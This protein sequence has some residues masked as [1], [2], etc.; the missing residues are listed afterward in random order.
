[1]DAE[2]LQQ[3]CAAGKDDVHLSGNSPL[4]IPYWSL[5]GSASENARDAHIQEGKPGSAC[6]KG[7]IRLNSEYGEKAICTASRTYQK[8]KLEEI[9]AMDDDEATIAALRNRLLKKA[10]IC[11]NLAGPATLKLGIDPKATPS[12]CCGPNIINFSQ[13]IKL[14][15][16]VGHIY[17]RLSVITTERVHMFLREL[18]MYID[19]MQREMQEVADHVANHTPKYF[20]EFKENMLEGIAYYVDISIQ[21]AED[22]QQK[23]L[24]D[25]AALRE[26]I[27]AIQ[28]TVP[29]PVPAT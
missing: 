25:L 14:E 8:Q 16:M 19:F 28:I 7:F 5:K 29:E 10:C 6:P 12:I 4:G 20:E 21:F 23:F 11:H 13:I 27:E 1:V 26:Q 17:G 22:K 9:E 18:S 2:H 3:L 15:D 24:N